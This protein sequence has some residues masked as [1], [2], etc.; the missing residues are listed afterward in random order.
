MPGALPHDIDLRYE[1][2]ELTLRGKVQP[3][4]A[5]GNLVFARTS[6]QDGKAQGITAFLV[7]VDAAGFDVPYYHWCL[8]MPTDHG[9]VTRC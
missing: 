6:G 8:N 4:E 3:S 7:D 1:R 5:H 9:E 2:G